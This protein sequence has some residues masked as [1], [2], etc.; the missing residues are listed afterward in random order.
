MNKT[1]LLVLAFVFAGITSV[2]ANT[3]KDEEAE[4]S[5]VDK[6]AATEYYLEIGSQ[7]GSGVFSTIEL[8]N[9]FERKLRVVTRGRSTVEISFHEEG[10][11]YGRRLFYTP[12]TDGQV[13][14]DEIKSSEFTIST[15]Y[16]ES[17]SSSTI[18][19]ETRYYYIR[20]R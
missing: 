14:T 2:M 12:N 20:E 3:S 17:S 13:I 5:S 6:K 9:P 1:I 19:Y 7:S 8:I 4:V 16:N 18:K 10:T 11:I 15:S